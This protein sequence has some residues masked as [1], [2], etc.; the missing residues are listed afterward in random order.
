MTNTDQAIDLLN[1]ALDKLDKDLD[2]AYQIHEAI[3]FIKAAE[4]DVSMWR[5]KYLMKVTEPVNG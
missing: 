2:P 5:N 3:K 4:N 1:Q